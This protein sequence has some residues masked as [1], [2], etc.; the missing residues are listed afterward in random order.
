MPQL[1]IVIRTVGPEM[2]FWA[3]IGAIVGLGILSLF[4]PRRKPPPEVTDYSER[5]V[6]IK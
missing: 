4:Q 2:F 5:H 1:E 3:C 6:R